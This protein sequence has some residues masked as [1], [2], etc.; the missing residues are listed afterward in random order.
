MLKWALAALI[1]IHALIHFWGF[2]AG[3]D[4][5]KAAGFHRPI[6]PGFGWLWFLA[7]VVLITA[8]IML[9][10]GSDRW[11]LVALAGVIVS[12]VLL[13]MWWQDARYGTIANL[14]I[15]IAAWGHIFKSQ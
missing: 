8:A 1:L 15:V 7:A 12:Q 11:R 2:G 9:M 4:P 13:V 3:M 10:S 14:L 5:R 6:S